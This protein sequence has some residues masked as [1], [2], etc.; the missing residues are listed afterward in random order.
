MIWFE[1]LLSKLFKLA[2]AGNRIERLH[3][4]KIF[5]A[6][7][8]KIKGKR[9]EAITS[10]IESME[11]AAPNDILMYFILYLD[12]V[13]DLLNETYKIQATSK[14]KIP[15][16]FVSKLK[17]AIEKRK[18]LKKTQTET[19]LSA[20]E[21]DTLKRIAEDLTNQEIADK[22]FISLNTVKT[23]VRNILLKL[24]VDNRTKAVTKAKEIGII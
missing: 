17:H 21:L 13:D 15:K 24:E 10:L 11:Y 8:Y 9:K 4:L 5:Y 7:L 12:K 20:R 2:Q 1:I 22:L 19:E 18:K 16:E 3:E 6:I 14:T 23:H